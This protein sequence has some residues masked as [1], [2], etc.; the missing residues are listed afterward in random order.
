MVNVARVFRASYIHFVARPMECGDDEPDLEAS[1][2]AAFVARRHVDDIGP[3]FGAGAKIVPRLEERA[4]T[5]NV[6]L[7]VCLNINGGDPPDVVKVRPS[8]CFPTYV[9][10]LIEKPHFLI[11]FLGWGYNGIFGTYAV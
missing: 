3:E 2:S 1:C 11:A 8:S 5:Y 4:R 9:I 7:L 10:Y 6:M